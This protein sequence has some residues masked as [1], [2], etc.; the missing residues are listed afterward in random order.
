MAGLIANPVGFGP[1]RATIDQWSPKFVLKF[2]CN[3]ATFGAR[4][5]AM[6]LGPR[7]ESE[8]GLFLSLA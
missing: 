6:V 2:A 8:R 3:D 5:V 7:L 1:D 4:P